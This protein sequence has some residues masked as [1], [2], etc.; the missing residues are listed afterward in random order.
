MS[1]SGWGFYS[2]TS[3][4]HRRCV[5]NRIL[6]T[7]RFP[8]RQRYSLKPMILN[9]WKA[10]GNY[11]NCSPRT[12]Q[13][14]AQSGL[15]IHRPA[16]RRRGVVITFTEEVEAWLTGSSP[17]TATK[18]VLITR[19]GVRAAT[20]LPAVHPS[21]ADLAAEAS[22]AKPVGKSPVP[23]GADRIGQPGI[24]VQEVDLVSGTVI[25]Q[26]SEGTLATFTPTFL[27]ANRDEGR[28]KR[29]PS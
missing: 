16:A 2:P 19:E 26:F 5:R 8:E 12:A 15:P 27:Y 20:A 18:V 4:R 24:Q 6:A 22:R 7:L 21:G 23:A 1:S 17:V 13:R 9:G 29:R 25:V 28:S 3:D 11:L 10:I 14:W